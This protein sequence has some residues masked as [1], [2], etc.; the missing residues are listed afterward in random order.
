M[1]GVRR[2]LFLH[3]ISGFGEIDIIAE[4][5]VES[6]HTI[7]TASQGKLE[8]ARKKDAAKTARR[9]QKETAKPPVVVSASA[10]IVGGYNDGV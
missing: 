9:K 4:Q 10:D 6:F 3:G 2:I 7:V 8:E 1:G 5:F